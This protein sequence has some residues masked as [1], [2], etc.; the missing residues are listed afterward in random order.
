MKK[1]KT[2]SAAML[3]ALVAGLAVGCAGVKSGTAADPAAS[4]VQAQQ[5]GRGQARVQVQQQA[6]AQ[7]QGRAQGEST[8][9]QARGGEGM[10][11]AALAMMQAGTPGE[12][13]R[14]L[15]RFV[16]SWKGTFKMRMAPDAPW[17]TFEG[18]VEREWVLDGRFLH[19]TVK[20]DS[21]MG[22]FEGISYMGYDNLEG[23]Y[24]TVWMDSTTTAIYR[25]VGY[26]D[27]EKQVLRTRGSMRDPAS[28]K[29]VIGEGELDLSDPDR[30]VFKGWSFGTDGRRF[31]SMEG[32][33]E[34]RK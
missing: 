16:G 28:G 11:A 26:Y 12:H 21:P 5:Q 33:T 14:L 17:M 29:I 3:M 8:Q 19:E 34:R 15:D 7:V 6:Q 24:V 30:Q 27:A 2:M 10:D 13:H 9:I 23:R 4:Q 25:E 1:R 32:I 18:D 20:A 22:P 31:F